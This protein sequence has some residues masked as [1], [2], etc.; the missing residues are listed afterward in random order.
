MGDNVRSLGAKN[1]SKNRPVNVFT[2]YVSYK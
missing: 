2:C 1:S